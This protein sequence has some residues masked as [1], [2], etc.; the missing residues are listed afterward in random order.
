MRD[1][2]E[3]QL[4]AAQHHVERLRTLEGAPADEVMQRWN[5][6]ARQLRSV[7]SLASLMTNV[8]P[9]E[10]VRDL[11][12]DLEQRAQR[13]STDLGLDRDCHRVLAAVDP[14][15]LDAGGRRVLDA[16]AARLL[17]APAS[18]APTRSA[19]A[20]APS[21]SARPSWGCSSAG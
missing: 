4:I 6:I 10:A 11:A 15:A 16:G 17:A 2:G 21:T 13:A 18:T 20:S 8:H 3:A 14:D 1:R 12:E 9:D 5:E 7:A 19:S